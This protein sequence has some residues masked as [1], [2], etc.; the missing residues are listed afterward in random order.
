M[1]VL[2]GAF[3]QLRLEDETASGGHLRARGQAFDDFHMTAIAAAER[4]RRQLKTFFVAHEDR[5]FV[6]NRLDR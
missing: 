2:G 3:A 1:G 4:H 6:F 5:R